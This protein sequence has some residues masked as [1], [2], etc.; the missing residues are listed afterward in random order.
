MLEVEGIN[1]NLFFPD[2]NSVSFL[3]IVNPA[4]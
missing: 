1:Y 2:K 3:D 4:I